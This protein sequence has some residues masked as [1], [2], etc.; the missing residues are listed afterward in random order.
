MKD[1]FLSNIDSTFLNRIKSNLKKCKSINFS[2]SF[3]RK[4]G[5]VFLGREIEDALEKGTKGRI[6]TSTSQTFTD[7]R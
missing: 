6:I 2:V 1:E 7:I 4:P 3:I 5:L